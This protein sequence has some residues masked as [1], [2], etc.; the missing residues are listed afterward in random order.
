MGRGFAPYTF[1]AFK[2]IVVHSVFL[3]DLM[4]FCGLMTR[5]LVL[6]RI[7]RTHVGARA[8]RTQLDHR[9]SGPVYHQRTKA[10]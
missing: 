4:L 10:M 2:E 6:V 7:I 5:L 3:N 1:L 8:N 9:Q